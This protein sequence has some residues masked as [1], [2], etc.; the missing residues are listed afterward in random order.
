MIYHNYIVVIGHAIYGQQEYL[1]C[2]QTTVED[3]RQAFVELLTENSSVD[4]PLIEVYVDYILVSE[5]P[6]DMAEV[7]V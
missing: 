6:I 3:A 2:E 4:A 1:K 5:S 7:N